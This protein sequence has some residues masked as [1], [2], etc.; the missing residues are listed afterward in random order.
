MADDS[1]YKL[2]VFTNKKAEGFKFSAFFI[3]S[4]PRNFEFVKGNKQRSSI[5]Y[6]LKTT[7]AVASL[8]P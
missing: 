5:N 8:L 6:G 7:P 4:Q 2:M 1:H 3:Y